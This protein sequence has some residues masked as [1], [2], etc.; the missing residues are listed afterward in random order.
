MKRGGVL[1]NATLLFQRPMVYLGCGIEADIRV[2]TECPDCADV[3]VAV[4]STIH[5]P[6]DIIRN[7]VF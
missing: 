4:V 7:N 5:S 2:A 1:Q 6:R 3:G